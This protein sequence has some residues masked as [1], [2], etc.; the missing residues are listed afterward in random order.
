MLLSLADVVNVALS[1]VLGLL[2]GY[3]FERRASRGTRIQNEEL[4]KQVNQLRE[5]VLSLGGSPPSQNVSAGAADIDDNLLNWAK[6]SQGPNGL[7]RTSRLIE[8]F[9]QRGSA[10]ADVLASIDR[11]EVA[12]LIEHHG[13]WIKIK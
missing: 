5:L 1:L 11:L 13:E 12:G 3:Y 9:I 7:T 6:R 8:Y 4:K 2:T 10:R